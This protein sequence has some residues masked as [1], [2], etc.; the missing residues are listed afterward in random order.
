MFNSS[1]A[2]WFL[3]SGLFIVLPTNSTTRLRHWTKTT[4]NKAQR[5]AFLLFLPLWRL[6]LARHRFPGALT[7]GG[8]VTGVVF[9]VNQSGFFCGTRTPHTLRSNCCRHQL[10]CW[11]VNQPPQ[12]L[13]F[14]HL[15]LAVLPIKP[16][17][18]PVQ[19]QHHLQPT[20]TTVQTSFHLFLEVQKL[21]VDTQADRST[22]STSF[23]S[24][25]LPI[26][27]STLRRFCHATNWAWKKKKRL[28]RGEVCAKGNPLSPDSRVAI[29]FFFSLTQELSCS[30]LVCVCC[31]L[32][33][34]TKDAVA[35][36]S[37]FSYADTFERAV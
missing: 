28:D 27:A 37:S 14:P 19:L 5:P 2:G 21:F 20:W 12:M 31:V 13:R 1:A 32:S 9:T 26:Q 4:S 33:T 15:T 36:D 17:S 11:G 22:P 30:R 29:F 8:V 23:S 7:R 10:G 25:S 16:S 3:V 18:V 35:A 34:V 24:S 6:L